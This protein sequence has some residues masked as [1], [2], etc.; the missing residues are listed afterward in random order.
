MQI[1]YADPLAFDD[2]VLQRVMLLLPQEKQRS[3]A[4]IKHAPTRRQATVAW[5]LLLL[6]MRE[7]VPGEALPPLGFTEAGKPF[8]EGGGP[9]FNLS[10]TDTLVCLALDG[11]PVGIDAQTPVLPS[12]G[13]VRRVLAPAEQTLFEAA[14]DKAAVF[15]ALWTQKEAYVK[16]TGE[17]IARGL[18]SLDFALYD[19]LDSFAAYDCC[20]SVFRLYGA[21]MTVCG[22][23]KAESLRPVTQSMI[24][25]ALLSSNHG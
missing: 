16:R 25:T 15:T 10:H 9:H 18:Q 7:S 20:F 6:A 14:Q 19:G 17:G 5:A 12:D 13:V 1:Y 4:K 3:I 21:V 22:G 23:T 11:G 2:A 24:Q 8:F